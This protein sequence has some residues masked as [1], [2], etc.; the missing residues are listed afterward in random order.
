MSRKSVSNR[1]S[2]KTNTNDKSDQVL[3][4]TP[5][6]RKRPSSDRGLPQEG[7]L[8]KLATEYL[9]RQGKHWPKLVEAGLLP[10]ASAKVVAEMVA[11]FKARH[12]TG[13]VMPEAV[14]ELAAFVKYLGGSYNRYSCDN[15]KPVSIIDQLSKNLD[16]AA[17]E[18]RF[19]PWA[20]VFADYSVSGLTAARQGYSS[21]K[22]V[23]KDPRHTIETTY[24]TKSWRKR[25]RSSIS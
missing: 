23:L 1:Q 12:R 11:D 4:R 15:S 13:E 2:R 6:K 22:R 25:Y 21:Y 10:E 17:T 3:P 24:I 14:A 5:R 16:K 19:I 9:N 7:E 8:S 20:Y 18:G